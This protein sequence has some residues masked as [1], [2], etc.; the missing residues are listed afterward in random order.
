MEN[1]SRR[2]QLAYM[3]GLIEYAAKGSNSLKHAV[4]FAKKQGIVANIHVGER[5]DFFE[6]KN[7]IAEWMMG[8]FIDGYEKEEY[9]AFN[10]GI[11]LAMSFL[12]YEYGY[13]LK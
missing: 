4:D 8:Q 1:S 12:N 7:K 5:K 3:V 9:I 2:E 6:D 13:N 10:S 11:N